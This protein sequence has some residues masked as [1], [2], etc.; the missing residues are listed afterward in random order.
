MHK[1]KSID[2]IYEILYEDI[3]RIS[4]QITSDKN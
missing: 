2:K 1:I 4:K 3:Y